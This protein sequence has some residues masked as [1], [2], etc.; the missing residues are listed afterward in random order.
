MIFRR[1][2]GAVSRYDLALVL[3]SLAVIPLFY[4]S[5][6][7]SRLHLLRLMAWSRGWLTETLIGGIGRAA[8][9]PALSE[10]LT[11]RR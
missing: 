11:I 6:W 10:S 3:L 8:A 4:A 5:I 7:L 2:D 9:R 1:K